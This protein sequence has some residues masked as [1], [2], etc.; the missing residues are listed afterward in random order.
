MRHQSVGRRVKTLGAGL[1]QAMMSPEPAA[2][3]DTAWRDLQLA[4]TGK[5]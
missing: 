4:L 1:P 3:K 2:Q 5:N